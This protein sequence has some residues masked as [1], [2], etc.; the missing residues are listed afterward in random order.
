MKLLILFGVFTCIW[1]NLLLIGKTQKQPADTYLAILFVLYGFTLGGAYFEAYN[2]EAGL[3]YP[4]LMHISWLF[5]LLHGPALWYYIQSVTR[6]RFSLKPLHGLHGLPFLCF[7]IIQFQYFAGIPAAE[8]TEIILE[9]S[10]R[11]T[12]HYVWS[13]RSIGLSTCLYHLWAI[14]Q[15]HDLKQLLNLSQANK[16]NLDLQW[17][18]ILSTAALAMYAVNT[19]LVNTLKV[20][21]TLTHRDAMLITYSIASCY[22]VALGY[23]GLQQK[24]VFINPYPQAIEPNS[25]VIVEKLADHTEHP[26]LNRILD[27]M[28][29]QRP[30]LD[31]DISLPKLSKQLDMP[32][33]LLSRTIHQHLGLHFPDFINQYRIKTYK[34]LRND[35]KLNYLS[36]LG[37]AYTAG[38]NSKASFYRAAKK[39]DEQPE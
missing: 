33:E 23:Y 38:F 27:Y 31:P 1:V 10:F 18:K 5:L 25:P 20:W 12:W 11:D 6:Q 24:Q 34:L 8:K 22:V 32:Q 39:F 3:P 4:H 9:E 21:E 37:V 35:P 28:E 26:L 30:Y 29:T 17:I 13:V 36:I 19:L 7:T 2:L 15:I 16:K 14:W